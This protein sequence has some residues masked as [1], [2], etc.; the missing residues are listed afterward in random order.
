[1]E[2]NS[3]YRPLLSEFVA[4]KTISTN[5][6]YRNDIEKAVSW[7]ERTYT[8]H[9]FDVRVVSGYGNPVVVARFITNPEFE[10]CLIYGHYDVQPAQKDGWYGDPF[11]VVEKDGRLFA[12]GVIDNKGQVLVHMATIFALIKEKR[13]R[14]NVVFMIEGDEETGSPHLERFIKENADV[15]QADFA[16][17]SDGEQTNDLPTIELGFRGGFNATVT[18]KTSDKDLHSGLFGGAIPNAGYVMSTLLSKLHDENNR[19]LIPGFY[20]TVDPVSETIQDANKKIPFDFETFKTISG[21]R[22]LLT[23]DAYDFHTQIGFMPNVDITG[24]SVGYTG[25][26][27]RNAI[28]GNAMAKINFR[29]TAT[30]DPETLAKKFVEF[31]HTS[32]PSYADVQIDVSF[33]YRGIAIS[34]DNPYVRRAEESFRI[35]CHADPLRKYC[36]GGLPIV[37]HYNDHLGIPQVLAP[38]ANEDCN[39]HGVNENFSLVSLEKAL[40]FSEHFFSRS[41]DMH[42]I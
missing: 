3:Q 12:R 41:R 18:I 22:A 8:Q 14:Y 9:A 31:V 23:H 32:M 29:L 16:L 2:I 35:A 40:A 27:Y 19:V 28:P 24:V 30:Q 26:G 36:G 33:P 1:M 39:M 25:E 5:S 42:A 11:T 4:F 10:T 20:D 15:L 7:L 38:L 37:T 21:T 13:L 6:A 17:I 34:T